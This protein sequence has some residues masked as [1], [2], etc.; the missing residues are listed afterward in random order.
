MPTAIVCLEKEYSLSKSCIKPTTAALTTVAAPT[1]P[2]AAAS[3][4]TSSIYACLLKRVGITGETPK[5]GGNDRD[6]QGKLV[7]A[8]CELSSIRGGCLRYYEICNKA[9]LFRMLHDLLR[10][11]RS[12]ALFRHVFNLSTF[13]L[14][15]FNLSVFNLSV[16]HPV[17]PSLFSRSDR[18]ANSIA[19]ASFP[20][21]TLHLCR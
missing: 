3:T 12:S 15:I 20:R 19:C 1:V 4:A 8:K 5:T 10:H 13:N 14:S 17:C 11:Q 9:L 18:L 6:Y 16:H 7:V 21:L 2:A